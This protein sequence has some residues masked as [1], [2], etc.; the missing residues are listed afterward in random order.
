MK[1][2]IEI[3]IGNTWFVRTELENEDGT[4]T[5]IKGIVKPFKLRSVYLRIWIRRRVLILDLR[6]GI[7]IQTKSK[8][9]FK[10]IIGFYGV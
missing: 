6:E 8:E 3:G 9:N 10:I 2:Y 4:E 1:K 7:K 5:E